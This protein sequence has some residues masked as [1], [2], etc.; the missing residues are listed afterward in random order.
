MN[1]SVKA[2]DTPLLSGLAAALCEAL[3][4][5]APAE[6]DLLIGGRLIDADL[7]PELRLEEALQ[8][9]GLRP[10]QIHA[11]LTEAR[12][13]SDPLVARAPASDHSIRW[14]AIIGARRR[15]LKVVIAD[16][17]GIRRRLMTMK[18]TAQL[19]G[20]TDH[21]TPVAFMQVE[22]AL[23]LEALRLS[24]AH[25]NPWERVRALMRLERQEISTLVVYA[26]VVGFLSLATPAAVQTLV[27]TVAFGTLLQ[28]LVVLTAVLFICLA[29][30]GVLRV[31]QYYAVEILQRR[32][33]V[34]VVL[35]LA[36]RL[37][38]V[39]E[40]MLGKY[41]MPELVNRFFDVVTVQKSASK[42]LLDGL[43]LGLQTLIGM[44][45]LA[46]YHPLLLALDVVLIGA[47]LVVL[48]VMGR[49]SSRTALAE[50]DAKY[51]VAAWLEDVA[52]QP[53]VF[54]SGKG[55]QAAL[56]RANG[57]ATT[58]LARRNDHY[59]I[60]LRQFMGGVGIQVVAN[61]LVLGI[62]GWL[63]LDGQLTLGQLVASEL[64]VALVVAG[65][66]KIGKQLETLYDLVAG[67][68]KIGKLV[69]LPLDHRRDHASSSPSGTA[70]TLQDVALP[71]GVKIP[72]MEMRPGDRLRVLATMPDCR[73]QFLGALEGQVPLAKGRIQL[74][75]E[76]VQR[77]SPMNLGDHVARIEGPAPVNGTI[78]EYL[79]LGLDGVRG[80]EIDAAL[81]AVDLL[82]TVGRLRGGRATRLISSGAPLSPERCALLAVA[83]ALLAGPQVLI[84]DD[85]LDRLPPEQR[86]RV[87]DN[88]SAWPQPMVLIIATH[89]PSDACPWDHSVCLQVGSDINGEEA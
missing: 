3:G 67:L 34:R 25:P 7:D 79:T 88:L 26:V 1:I 48:F 14:V 56:E 35:D 45:L 76:D 31:L 40:R 70:L 61:T 17:S 80:T 75:G 32:L 87:L 66:A 54:R 30:S 57:L 5:P 28:P 72:D 46:L 83:R 12:W 41:N 13:S 81:E 19:L 16:Q 53:Q 23:P 24:G 11:T 52:A 50:S 20:L 85:W 64:I 74:N 86:R 51:A 69:D 58:Y 38:Q 27:N 60:V 18:D 42:L 44:I 43:E 9:T 71:S 36:G 49:G 10:S 63:V 33:F 84:I 6:L 4:A 39:D 77:L 55:A 29:F 37:P 62:G 78:L 82:E 89:L 8:A 21:R 68:A 15:K 2:G 59:R 47:M 73:R 65:M 22:A